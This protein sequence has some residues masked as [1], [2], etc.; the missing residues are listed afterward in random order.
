M[1]FFMMSN[2]ERIF[3]Y[4]QINRLYPFDMTEIGSCII[5]GRID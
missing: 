2:L 5:N 3:A 1:H 4:E